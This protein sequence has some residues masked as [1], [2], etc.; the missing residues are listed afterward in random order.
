MIS[1]FKSSWIQSTL[2]IKSDPGSTWRAFNFQIASTLSTAEIG[3]N[4]YNKDLYLCRTG[5]A[6]TTGFIKIYKDSS[7][8]NYQTISDSSQ[9]FSFFSFTNLAAGNYTMWVSAKWLTSDSKDYAIRINS[10]ATIIIKE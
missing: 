8:L 10:T 5:S 7:I 9:E 3:I 2:E 1:Q 6:V 4:F